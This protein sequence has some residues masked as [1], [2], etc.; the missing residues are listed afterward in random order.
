MTR[1]E[2]LIAAAFAV[3]GVAGAVFT[4]YLAPSPAVLEVGA[5]A[6]TKASTLLAASPTLAG[7]VAILAVLWVAL[8]AAAAAQVRQAELANELP[9]SD[10]LAGAQ[11]FEDVESVVAFFGSGFVFGSVLWSIARDGSPAGIASLVIALISIAVVA[12]LYG[13]LKSSH[14]ATLTPEQTQLTHGVA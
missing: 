6:V 5:A 4:S 11:A 3:G 14:R 1:V 13:W 8:R 12:G 7:A 10:R 2:W 9:G